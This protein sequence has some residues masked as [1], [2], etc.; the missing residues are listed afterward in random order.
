MRA[1]V[2]GREAGRLAVHARR[3]RHRGAA[4]S[5]QTVRRVRGV[6]LEGQRELQAAGRRGGRRLRRRRRVRAGGQSVGVDHH[7]AARA[8][9]EHAGGVGPVLGEPESDVG[10]ALLVVAK[11]AQHRR[12]RRRRRGW[13]RRGRR[14][15][16]QR[17]QAGAAVVQ[18]GG[19]GH[20]YAVCLKVTDQEARSR[21]DA[22][23]QARV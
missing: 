21:A 3:V 19:V 9:R 4:G 11:G 1:A 12:E 16:R 2:P 6:A 18:G 8:V 10:R 13:R 23:L 7:G 17:H 15:R 14:W 5:G 20:R 22:L